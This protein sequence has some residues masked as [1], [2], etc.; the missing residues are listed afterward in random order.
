LNLGE[1]CAVF[2]DPHEQWKHGTCKGYKNEDLYQK[3]LADQ[4]PTAPEMRKEKRRE[5]AR[6]AHT[7]PH[8]DGTLS[9]KTPIIDRVRARR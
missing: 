8:Y 3:Y 7:E 4:V 1:R 6:L 9:H 2:A 5:R